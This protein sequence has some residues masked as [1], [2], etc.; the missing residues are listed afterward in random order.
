MHHAPR[1]FQR[2]GEVHVSAAKSAR[3]IVSY[4]RQDIWA[5]SLLDA[6][7]PDTRVQ[8]VAANSF[9]HAS[10]MLYCV[11]FGNKDS[12]AGMSE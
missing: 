7:L 6:F 4:R 12:A 8:K 5:D 1:W 10:L 11:H 9:S 3:A 2:G